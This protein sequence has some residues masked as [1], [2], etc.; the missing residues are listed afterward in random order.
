MD[1]GGMPYDVNVIYTPLKVHL[2][3]YNYVTDNTGLSLF[4]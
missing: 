3:D 4:V 1:D 2:M